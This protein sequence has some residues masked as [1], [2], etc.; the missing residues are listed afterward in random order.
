VD[1]LTPDISR[2]KAVA[3]PQFKPQVDD[4]E[5]RLSILFDHL[6]NEDLLSEVTVQ[7][8]VQICEAIRARDW[9]GALAQFTELQSSVPAAELG[10]W[11]VGVK[12]L[13]NMGKISKI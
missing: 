5:K 12:R 9:D 11:S 7:R 2:I 3:P 6:N 1:I 10:Q 4:M 13:I 8:V